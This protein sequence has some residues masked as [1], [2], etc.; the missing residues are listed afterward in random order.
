MWTLDVGCSMKKMTK[1]TMGIAPRHVHNAH[2]TGNVH[3]LDNL[4]M[5]FISHLQSR[6]VVDRPI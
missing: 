3:R 5:L 4:G 2:V 6:R 1:T